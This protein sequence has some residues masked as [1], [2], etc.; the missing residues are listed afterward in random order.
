MLQNNYKIVK[1]Q[2]NGENK[3]KNGK[4]GKVLLYF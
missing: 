3:N 1:K 4:F 2:K